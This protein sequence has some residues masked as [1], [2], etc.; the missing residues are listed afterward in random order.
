MRTCPGWHNTEFDAYD[1]LLSFSGISMRRFDI[2]SS[3][4]GANVSS[5]LALLQIHG[6]DLRV[7]KKIH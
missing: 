7:P 6:A 3:G 4:I 2:S 1:F 5:D